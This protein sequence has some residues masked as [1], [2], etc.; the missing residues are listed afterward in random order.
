MTRILLVDDHPVVRHGIKQVLTGA[1][2]PALVGEASSAEEGATELKNS[3]W[4]VIVLDLAL[5]GMSGLDWLR[6]L[7]RERPSVPV[8]ILSMYQPD[9]FARRAIHAGASGYLTKDSHPTELVKAVAE[10]IAGR[11][12]LNPEVIEEIAADL[13]TDRG[14]RG[15]RP[16]ESLSDREYQVMRMIASGLTVSQIALK[17][18]LSVKTIST[19][20]ARV[21]KKMEMKT[22]A[23]LMYYAIQHGLVD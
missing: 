18:S 19:F 17:L 6:E 5:P 15:S 11:R 14:D 9:Q 12:Y 23:E 4:D 13:E 20:R 16:H 7:R 8:L 10:V 2:H 22:T 3:P 1:F 21:L